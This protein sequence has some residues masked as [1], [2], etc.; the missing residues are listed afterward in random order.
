MY[1]RQINNYKKNA[2]NIIKKIK[3]KDSLIKSQLEPIQDKSFIVFHDAYQYF[4]KAYG[5]NTLGSILLDPELPPS[6]KRIMQIRT[7]IKSMKPHCVFKEP[8]F[9]AKIVDT[10]IENTNVKV[11]ILDPLGAD[12]ESGPQMYTNLLQNISDN[13]NACLK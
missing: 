3:A 6:P 7:K 13:L 12:L 9:R 1:K 10:V 8:Q 11:G 5:L 4:E 2:K